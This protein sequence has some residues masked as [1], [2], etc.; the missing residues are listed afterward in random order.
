[1]EK[2]KISRN[3]RNEVNRHNQRSREGETETTQYRG[4]GG[5]KG[6]A[7]VK[8]SGANLASMVE[9]VGGHERRSDQGERRICQPWRNERR[10]DDGR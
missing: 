1:M 4:R 9:E 5:R 8:R 6:G 10:V 7:K 3:E 2:E